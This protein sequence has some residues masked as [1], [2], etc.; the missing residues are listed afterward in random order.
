RWGGQ[1]GAA[2]VELRNW[3]WRHF[4]GQ[5]DTAQAVLRGH[6]AAATTM[7]ISPDGRRLASGSEDGAVAL[8]DARA[9]R[10]I[11]IVRGHDK[12]VWQGIF[13]P[14][15]RPLAPAGYGWVVPLW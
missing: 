1:L 4:A 2:P 15:C 14:H 13:R 6:D 12:P 10:L 5:L 11:A 7:A 8:W 3:E 9:A